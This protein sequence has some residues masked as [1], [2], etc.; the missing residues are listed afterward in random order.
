MRRD[1]FG[2]QYTPSLA[3]WSLLAKRD[4]DG[5][6]VPVSNLSEHTQVG[7]LCVIWNQHTALSCYCVYF[8]FAAVPPR[9][10]ED[11]FEIKGRSSS[12]GSSTALLVRPGPKTGVSMSVLFHARSGA[13][14]DGAGL[15]RCGLR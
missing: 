14:D 5:G 7:V 13:A 11:G 9:K 2:E 12:A 6:R 4:A 1:L 3:S 8:M 15:V 10:P